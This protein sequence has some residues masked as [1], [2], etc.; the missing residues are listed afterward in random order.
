MDAVSEVKSRLSVEDVL[1]EYV[2]LKRAG[3]NFKGLSPFT[4]EKT[5]SFVVSPEKQIWH[6]FSS[7]KGGD[8]FSFIME[9]EG[10]D[11]KGALDLLARK[12]GLN[13]DELK[14]NR[15]F[16]VDKERLYDVL[17]LST[18]FYQ[19]QLKNNLSG[20]E[21]VTKSRLFSKQTLIDFQLGYSPNVGN[22]LIKF[23]QDKGYPMSTIRLAGLAVNRSGR[24]VD[25]FRGRLMIPLCDGFGRVVGFTA[26]Q[27]DQNDTG[28][29]YINTP[30]TP[31]Y[32]KSRHVYGL[33]LA[34]KSIREVGYSVICEGNLD[35]IASH[36]AGRKCAVAT[37]G[38]AVTEQQLKALSHL[39]AEVRIAFDQDR[40]GLD[41]VERVIPIASKLG[42]NTQI[43]SIPSGKDPDELIKKDPKLWDEAI[44][45]ARPSFDWLIDRLAS[46][47]NLSTAIGKRRFSDEIISL[48]SSVSDKIEQD[49]YIKQLAQVLDV[50]EET[51]Q[52]KLHTNSKTRKLKP[53]RA[54]KNLA[55]DSETKGWQIATDRLLSLALK[56]PGTR[57]YLDLLEPRM[58]L[59]ER[60]KELLTQIKQNLDFESTSAPSGALRSTTDYVNIISLQFDELYSKVDALELQ[61]E[62]A[63]LRAKIIEYFVKNEKNRLVIELA[64][65]S[66]SEQKKL[67]EQSREL[68]RL[69]KKVKE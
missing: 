63:R 4:N 15:R 33:H 31:L 54:K 56:L 51:I 36:Q 12:A 44:K 24:Y 67:L 28:P 11:F 41:A 9:V 65:A 50:N 2:Q 49:H 21:Y 29:K 30:S 69:L 25:M 40:A 46:K 27:L 68:D 59:E 3:R 32:D 47:H 34:K 37:A 43:V 38:T 52:E 16:G 57:G 5:P 22:G 14:S 7:G 53:I 61:F 1:S 62:A 48:V 66:E 19:V 60:S 64:D 20:W 58:L 45:E 39:S 10:V 8:I 55:S 23:L 6:D 26:R 17:S 35:V 13:L 18:K 42:V